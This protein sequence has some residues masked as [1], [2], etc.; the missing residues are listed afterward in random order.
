MCG[1]EWIDAPGAGE[2]SQRAAADAGLNRTCLK[3]V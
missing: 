3:G 1:R 2:W